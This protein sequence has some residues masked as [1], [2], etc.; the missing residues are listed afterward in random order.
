MIGLLVGAAILG[1]IISIVEKEEFPGW[2]KMI[3]CV[4]A[5]WIPAFAL[6]KVLPPELFFIGSLVGAICAAATIFLLCGTTIKRA[7][8]SAG[9][10][11]AVQF[12]L[13]LILFLMLR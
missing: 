13:S 3:V 8:I 1:I 12:S 4:L 9:I 6:S 10:Y 7:C 5:A 2:G 11:L